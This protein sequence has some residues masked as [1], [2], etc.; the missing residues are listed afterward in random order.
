[1]S[2]GLTGPTGAG[3]N[4]FHSTSTLILTTTLNARHYQRRQWSIIIIIIIIIVI[5]EF[6]VCLLQCGHEHRCI[7]LSIRLKSEAK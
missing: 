6:I 5:K 2:T 3:G 4:V 1:M 7:A